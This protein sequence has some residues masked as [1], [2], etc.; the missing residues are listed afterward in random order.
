MCMTQKNISYGI[1]SIIYPEFTSFGTLARCEDFARHF[2]TTE[3]YRDA[4]W[5]DARAGYPVA[6][7]EYLSSLNIIDEETGALLK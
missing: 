1:E 7:R 3:F 6:I 5:G 4:H 2:M